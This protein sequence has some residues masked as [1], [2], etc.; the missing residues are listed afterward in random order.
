[1]I[2]EITGDLVENAS[3]Y[4]VIVHGVNCHCT[5]RSGVAKAIRER[6]PEAYEVDL[7]TV[8]GDKSKLGTI[9]HTINTVPI[10]V[11]AYT[12]YNYL[13]RNVVNAD[14]NAI[15][16]CMKEIR[17]KFH[18]KKI[19]LPKIGAGLAGGDWNIIRQIIEEELSDENVTIVIWKEQ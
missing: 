8:K 17:K 7:K 1:L 13:P 14:Y 4:D 6:F 3:D 5:M 11:N 10:V 16:S 18:G 19:G 2:K 12:Q 15:R 9:S